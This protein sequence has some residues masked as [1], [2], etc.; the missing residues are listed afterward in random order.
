MFS[1][2]IKTVRHDASIG[3]GLTFRAYYSFQS[4]LSSKATTY[5]ISTVEDYIF[6]LK[7]LRIYNIYKSAIS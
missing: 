7:Q 2:I 1:L 3:P 6:E 5:Q 4:F